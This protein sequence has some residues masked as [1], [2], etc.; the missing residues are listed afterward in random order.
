[1]NSPE[2]HSS[3]STGTGQAL[4]K[5]R[6][7]AVD[8][9][10]FVIAA[11]APLVGMTGALPAAIVLGNGAAAPGAYLL[12]GLV[13]LLF[14]IGYAAMSH[15]VTN[16]GAF[17]AYIGRGLGIHFGV[18]S[19][20]T[21]LLAYLAIH[22][23]V[24]GFFGGL[25]A[26]QVGGLP[27]WGWS[28]VAWCLVTYL[29]LRRV[30]VGARILGVL[31]VLELLVLIVTSVAIFIKGGPELVQWGASFNPSNILVGGLAG[32][33]GIAF[34]FA[35]ASFIGFE[36]T[37]IY[38]EEAVNPKKTVPRAT[39]MAVTLIATLFAVTSFAV[40][41]GL[42]AGNVVD[43]V[44]ELTT[45]DGVPLANPAAVL[46]T[47]ASTYVAPWLGKTMEVLVIS[48]MFAGL[49]AFQN[50]ASRYFYALGRAGTLPV[51]LSRVNRWGAPA[52]G[53]LATS[54]ITAMVIF[55]FAVNGLDPVVNMFFWFSGM[56]VLSIL[57][58]EI[59]V[60]FA[61]IAFFHSNPQGV[62][63]L[64]SK[65]APALASIGLA[66]GLYL[67]MSR[68]GLLTGE[69]AE[70][71]D[72]T[73]MAWGL[74]GLGWFMLWLPFAVLALGGLYSRMRHAQKIEVIQDVV[75]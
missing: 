44:V 6:L 21:S 38:G 68:F 39:Y 53:S 35:F 67:L 5:S 20:F 61:V 8:I 46:F 43:K 25:V 1:M 16:V 2:P 18:G 60:C 40:V 23:S 64:Q 74:N 71:V 37:A 33:A 63:L 10:F 30:D 42:G 26:E 51:A 12:V 13:L 47:L 17:F 72:P 69:V 22:L 4:E 57:L 29:S 15:R 70:G 50:S 41:T 14:S 65:I 56:A 54:G 48:S 7:V 45:V 58:I 49:L 9:V 11:A 73:V 32:S 28:A 52:A 59:L 62:N 31:L 34:A 66:V 75:T 24:Y 55:L 3:T 36:A 27:W 19:A